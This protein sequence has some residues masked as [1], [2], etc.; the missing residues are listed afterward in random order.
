MFMLSLIGIR[1]LN[2]V[3]EIPTFPV[4]KE[5]NGIAVHGPREMVSFV[6]VIAFKVLALNCQ[7][8]MAA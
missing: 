7:V 6:I 1:D 2:I 3:S 4:I 5:L 8:N